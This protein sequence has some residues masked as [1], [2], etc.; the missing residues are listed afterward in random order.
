MNIMN[1]CRKAIRDNFSEGEFTYLDVAAKVREQHPDVGIESIRL[2]CKLLSTRKELVVIGKTK[3]GT[4]AKSPPINIY[5]AFE[6][7]DK[8][9]PKAK[10]SKAREY[11]KFTPYNAEGKF[12]LALRA[13]PMDYMQIEERFGSTRPGITGMMKM[14]YVERFQDACY[15]ITELGL[16]VCPS[17][18]EK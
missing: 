3:K 17:R 13:G 6:L 9:A 8:E 7:Y 16:S 1:E 4:N 15:R 2:N 11:T 14:G 5:Q 18:R 10:Q 12:L